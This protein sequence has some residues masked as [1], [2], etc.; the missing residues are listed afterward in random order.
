MQHWKVY[1]WRA[2]LFVVSYERRAVHQLRLFLIQDDF[3]PI[4]LTIP[5]LD[6]T[7]DIVWHKCMNETIFYNDWPP[8]R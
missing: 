6:P 3:E 2:S 1:P 8:V 5:G 7:K 4:H